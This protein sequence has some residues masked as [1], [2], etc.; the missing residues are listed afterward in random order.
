MKDGGINVEPVFQREL[1]AQNEKH[2]VAFIAAICVAI[3]AYIGYDYL[4]LP[5][6]WFQMFWWRLLAILCGVIVIVLFLRKRISALCAWAI[7]FTINALPLG[8][9]PN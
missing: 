2:I 3:A 4:A 7:F 5:A 1:V 6:I 9:L 8:Y